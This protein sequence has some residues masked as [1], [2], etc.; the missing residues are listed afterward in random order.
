MEAGS[1]ASRTVAIIEDDSVVCGHLVAVIARDPSLS[2][3]GTAGSV[4]EGVELL[5]RK[6]DIAI[7]DIGLSDGSG[8]E[9]LRLRETED[10]GN[11]R[12]LILTVFGDETSVMGALAAGADGYLVKD[13][14]S[15]QFIHGL[16]DVLD[17]GT[18]L[19]AS[20]ATYL[21]RN[22]RRSG[23]G[24]EA[25]DTAARLSAREIELLRLFAT[26][27]TNKEAARELALSPHTV[28][29]YVKGIFRKL[30]VN[31]R[32]EAV[33]KAVSGRLLDS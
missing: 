7:L 23:A 8:I 17:G 22:F 27:L 5:R 21:L 14:D 20:I 15:D 4:A 18:P 9:L 30:Q 2:L 16:H 25:P 3:I 29:D 1:T 32:A 11:C 12:F 10:F 24:E 19:S 13:M 31:S 28:S 26:G 33:F 6:P